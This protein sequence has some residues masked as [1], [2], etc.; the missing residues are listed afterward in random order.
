M[1]ENK[2]RNI[3]VILPDGGWEYVS[4]RME[5][6]AEMHGKVYQD[7]PLKYEIEL[8]DDD[9]NCRMEFCR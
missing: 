6:L 2:G 5:E 7:G 9:G 3:N 4:G 1:F 8:F